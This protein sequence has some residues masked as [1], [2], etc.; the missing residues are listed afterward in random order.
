M[1]MSKFQQA[2]ERADVLEDIVNGMRWTK[3]YAENSIK[4]WEDKIEGA[5][6]DEDTEWMEENRD[7]YAYRLSVIQE[8]EK[9]L[10]K[11]L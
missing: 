4:E 10:E 5:E 7:K 9:V 1:A 2:K 8:V 11:M 3:E 6:E